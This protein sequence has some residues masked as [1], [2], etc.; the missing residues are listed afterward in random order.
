M[1]EPA[2]AE[3]LSMCASGAVVRNLSIRPALV[4]NDGMAWSAVWVR[5]VAVTIED[6]D[7]SSHL[8]ATVWVG[9]SSSRAIVRRCLIHDGAQNGVAARDEGTVL[10]E[11]CDVTG[12]RWPGVFAGGP[13]SSATVRR[14][15]ITDNF[16]IGALAN[17]SATLVVE[18]SRLA[19]NAHGGVMLDGAAPASGIE[20]N[21]V[22]TNAEEGILVLAGVGG[23]VRD[24]RLHRNQLG[25]VVA[26]GASPGIAGNEV[27][28]TLGPAI[29]VTGARSDPWVSDNTLVAPRA[30]AIVVR[31][32]GAG[33][34]ERNRIPAGRQPGVWILEHGS[35]PIFMENTISGGRLIAIAVTGH[36]GGL[37]ERNDLRGNTGGSWDLDDAGPV[38][39]R[40]NL[41]DPRPVP[42]PPESV[43]YVN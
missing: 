15:R 36:A 1:L 6:C 26:G 24:N 2:G 28:D 3:A 41:E 20:H 12:N 27:V 25:I 23:L 5:D 29:L 39:L 33:R 37:F 31:D 13:G 42:L 18:H 30:A 43:G 14:S 9:G 38:E 32:E 11:D 7:L 35:S 21:E 4:G 16:D 34:F 19:R 8:G 17:A 10:V 40:G 22:E